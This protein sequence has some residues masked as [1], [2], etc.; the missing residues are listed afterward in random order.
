MYYIFI[1]NMYTLKKSSI[2]IRSQ[3]LPTLGV[4]TPLMKFN[5]F[6]QKRKRMLFLGDCVE[7][8]RK[9][10]LI[11]EQNEAYSWGKKNFRSSN[12]R[13]FTKKGVLTNFTKFTENICARAFFN[14][15]A[16]L[17]PATLFKDSGT[18]VFLCILKF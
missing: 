16:G 11:A 12:Q 1:L 10:I 13:C 8:S 15:A 18:G 17:R 7:N 2:S 3:I 4:F 5:W 14:K 9:I 6:L